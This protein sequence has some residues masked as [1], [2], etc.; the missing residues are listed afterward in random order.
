[1]KFTNEAHFISSRLAPLILDFQWIEFLHRLHSVGYVMCVCVYGYG[2]TALHRSHHH[3]VAVTVQNR[4]F[5]TKPREKG[6]QFFL[7]VHI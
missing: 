2:V 1:M 4:T 7:P 3:D 6:K 5:V